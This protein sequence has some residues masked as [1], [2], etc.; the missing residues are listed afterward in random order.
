MKPTCLDCSFASISW[1][2]SKTLLFLCK[3]LSL[4]QKERVRLPR[5]S[6]SCFTAMQSVMVTCS[7]LSDCSHCQTVPGQ[8]QQ[9]L[10][11]IGVLKCFCKYNLLQRS[12][13]GDCKM[14]VRVGLFCGHCIW[15]CLFIVI[16][17]LGVLNPIIIDVSVFINATGQQGEGLVAL[18]YSQYLHSRNMNRVLLLLNVVM[19]QSALYTCV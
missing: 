10:F 14:I 16:C 11:V 7:L 2:R 1:E 15:R 17:F 9:A 13:I 19:W 5:C 4:T 12:G 18:H 6:E 3:G 8:L